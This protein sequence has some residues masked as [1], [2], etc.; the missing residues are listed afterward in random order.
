VL[1]SS[2]PE[3]EAPAEAVVNVQDYELVRNLLC[4]I[5]TETTSAAQD[6]LAVDMINRANVYLSTRFGQGQ[7][8]LT[9]AE[10][11]RLDYLDKYGG[12]PARRELIT[13]RELTDLGNVRSATVI[14]LVE[15]LQR[16]GRGRGVFLRMGIAGPPVSHRVWRESS[17]RELA[18]RLRPWSE[19]QVRVHFDRLRRDG[20]IT[21]ER[22]TANGPWRFAVPE[23]IADGFSPFADLPT[24]EQL[25]A[26][27]AAA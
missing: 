18:R 1:R 13:R 11:E 26:D 8:I 15:Q 16:S 25:A 2:H 20:L 4:S 7:N 12:N 21:A 14:G 19:K 27:C 10:L 22:D 5:T 3:Q 9:E 6:P 24:A 23:G 17:A